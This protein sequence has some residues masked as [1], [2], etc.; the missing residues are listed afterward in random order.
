MFEKTL[1]LWQ[2]NEAGEY[3]KWPF[4]NIGVQLQPATALKDVMANFGVMMLERE[5]AGR[6]LSVLIDRG[7]KAGLQVS[8]HMYN[9]D[10][11]LEGL[12]ERQRL[13][14]A[15]LNMNREGFIS[16]SRSSDTTVEYSKQ[17]LRSLFGLS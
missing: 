15:I 10:A 7:R 14:A 13:K 9:V 8:L 6:L 5:P 2:E 16:R 4:Y 17:K 3:Y 11:T 12:T 1:E